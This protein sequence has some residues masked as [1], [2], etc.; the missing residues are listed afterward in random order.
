M[1]GVRLEVVNSVMT[2]AEQQ[3]LSILKIAVH[4]EESFTI[5]KSDW[6]GIITTA[7]KQNLFPLIF[8]FSSRL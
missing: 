7:R 6:S 8:E 4:S 2:K 1:I 5:D 3:F